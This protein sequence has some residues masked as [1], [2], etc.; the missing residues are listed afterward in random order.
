M[1][2]IAYIVALLMLTSTH[3]SQPIREAK[4]HFAQQAY[5]ECLAA[6]REALGL[7]PKKRKDI[8][9]NMAQVF[10]E[11]QAYDS[12]LIYYELALPY[13]E[14]QTQATIYNNIGHLQTLLHD[15]P[16]ALL[17]FR[18]AVAIQPHDY[19]AVFNYELLYK[20]LLRNSNMPE[21]S[22]QASQ[23]SVSSNSNLPSNSS[24]SSRRVRVPL[25]SN[26]NTEFKEQTYYTDS[27]NLLEALEML[28]WIKNR[29]Y[30]YI[31]QLTKQPKNLPI[32]TNKPNW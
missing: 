2:N 26:R 17:S 31:Q 22:P 6:Y 30:Q 1:K 8:F 5:E 28:D 27:L 25:T 21:P 32:Q 11:T 4:Q 10:T 29:E 7:Y 18:K 12:A 24:Q 19:M 23:E 3:S 16:S 13:F 15:L 14:S 20:R 9:Y